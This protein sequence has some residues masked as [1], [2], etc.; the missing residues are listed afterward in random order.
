MRTSPPDGTGKYYIYELEGL[1]WTQFDLTTF[2]PTA[3]RSRP[4]SISTVIDIARTRCM[5]N[6]AK[7]DFEGLVTLG[8][9]GQT[10]RYLKNPLSTGL[11]LAS[12]LERKMLGLQTTARRRGRSEEKIRKNLADLHLEITYGFKPL[13]KDVFGILEQLRP[14]LKP[15]APRE[16]ARANENRA[17]TDSWTSTESVGG[18]NY[19]A[20]YAYEEELVVRP[21]ILYEHLTQP[22]PLDNWG[23]SLSAIPATA[24]EL[25]PLSF[26]VDRFVNIGDMISAITPR[27][28]IRNLATGYTVKTTRKLTRKVSNFV[29]PSQSYIA[30]RDGSGMDTLI[31]EAY[32]RYPDIG[33]PTLALTDIT[34]LSRDVGLLTTLLSLTTQKLSKLQRFVPDP[35]KVN[36]LAITVGRRDR[37]EGVNHL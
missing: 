15:Y 16:T 27:V 6:V 19:T 35:P 2:G 22:T 30:E 36:R 32:Y 10:L 25:V 8:E 31:E 23:I 4:Y 11:K 18:I 13:L 17:Y 7:P 24:W 12:T 3:G 21:Y 28:G 34:S 20:Q 26:I 1:G 33:V 37:W 5:A 29:V 9:I 14:K